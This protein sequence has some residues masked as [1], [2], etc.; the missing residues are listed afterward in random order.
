MTQDAQKV[1]FI[2]RIDLDIYKCIT[3][4]IVTDEVVITNNQ[5]EHIKERHEDVL[6]TILENMKEIIENPDYISIH[7][8]DESVSFIKKFDQ[9][10]SVAIKVSTAGDMVFRTMYPLRES[11]LN[12]Y[13]ASGRCWKIQP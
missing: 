3:E 7:P 11:Q 8:N 4:D 1:L 12:N 9:N 13:I 6:E 10:I 2:G 5:I